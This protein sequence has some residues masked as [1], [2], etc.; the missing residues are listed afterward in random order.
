MTD[1]IVPNSSPSIPMPDEL[2]EGMPGQAN[3]I[4]K[5]NTNSGRRIVYPRFRMA[6]DEHF[7]TPGSGFTPVMK[8][9]SDNSINLLTDLPYQISVNQFRHQIEVWSLDDIVFSLIQDGFTNNVLGEIRWDNIS[10]SSYDLLIIR[11]KGYLE[12]EYGAY[13]QTTGEILTPRRISTLGDL[14]IVKSLV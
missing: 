7:A 13:S 9:S 11:L 6:T 8:V 12:P 2:F 5:L 10:A 14:C 3:Y 1:F 4:M